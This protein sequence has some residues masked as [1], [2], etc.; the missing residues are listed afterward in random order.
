MK[1]SPSVNISERPWRHDLKLIE[2]ARAGDEQALLALLEAAQP[3]IRRYAARSC[4]SADDVD[5][6]V[7]ETLWLLYRRVG[8]V[9]ALTSISG[10]LVTVVR[11]ECARL[12]RRLF[13]VEP[14]DAEILEND[15]RLS[16]RSLVELRIDIAQ[17]IRSLPEHYRQVVLLRDIE[18]MSI[19]EIAGTLGLTRESTKARL[20][21]ARNLIREYLKD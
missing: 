17:A 10:W 1:Q 15:L 7:Q 3:D 9:R 21:R 20:H 14:T 4:R 16:V 13:G 19:D 12:A 2:A 6:A 8:T 18:E 5:D 11:R